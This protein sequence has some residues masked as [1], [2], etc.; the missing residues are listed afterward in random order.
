MS[1]VLSSLA[2]EDLTL[3]LLNLIYHCKIIYWKWF[4]QNGAAFRS[5]EFWENNFTSSFGRKTWIRF[6]GKWKLKAIFEQ[7]LNF[8]CLI[9]YDSYQHVTKLK[10]SGKI[11]YNG[12]ELNEFVPQ[13]TSLYI[14]QYDNHM[15]EMTVR[16]TIDFSARCQGVGSRY[17]W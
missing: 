13:R 6:T 16:E 10:V 7:I 17:G 11:T 3:E 12:R 9:V 15:G 1:V 14:S 2:G 8:F 5:S 4:L